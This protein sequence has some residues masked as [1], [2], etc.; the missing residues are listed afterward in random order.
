M[1]IVILSLVQGMRTTPQLASLSPK[2]HTTP[3]KEFELEIFNVHQPS[4]H[5]YL[6]HNDPTVN[7]IP[8]LKSSDLG[9]SLGVL[10][11]SIR[12]LLFAISA[13][14]MPRENNC[15]FLN[16]CRQPM[17]RVPDLACGTSISV[18]LHP[19]WALSRS[20]S[21]SGPLRHVGV[22]A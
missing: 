9:K 18:A 14:S 2:Y 11:T 1:G 5:G 15:F 6:G 12:S 17:A 22:I 7:R 16:K 21:T 4:L 8:T 3:R 20:L 19:G 13:A 10:F